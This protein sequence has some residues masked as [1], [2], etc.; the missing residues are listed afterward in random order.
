MKRWSNRRS[1]R[2][3]KRRQ[4]KSTV[5]VAV[6]CREIHPDIHRRNWASLEPGLRL[7]A[8][9]RLFPFPG[10]VLLEFSEEFRRTGRI[11]PFGITICP[12]NVAGNAS[13]ATSFRYIMCTRDF[14]PTNYYRWLI[15]LWFAARCF[16]TK[17][18]V[19]NRGNW[20]KLC[21]WASEG[22]KC[23]FQLWQGSQL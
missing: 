18:A 14:P 15:K 16:M 10:F 4:R 21:A 12:H 20:P 5:P 11:V 6:R 23:E 3:R 9:S 2:Y 13:S 19:G 7:S 8:P 22:G 17:A 1:H